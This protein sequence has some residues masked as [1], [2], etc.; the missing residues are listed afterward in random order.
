M[1]LATS[2]ILVI[3]L[4]AFTA[5]KLPAQNAV[6]PPVCETDPRYSEFDFWLGDWEVFVD[7]NKVGENTISKEEG[8]LPGP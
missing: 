8:R 3:L 7:D 6:P 5:L 4:T 1:K 2:I